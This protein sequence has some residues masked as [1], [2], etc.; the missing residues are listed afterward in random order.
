M[1]I[2]LALNN[3][4][5]FAKHTPCCCL[6]YKPIVHEIEIYPGK[7]ASCDK[8]ILRLSQL[9]RYASI[10]WVRSDDISVV[11]PKLNFRNCLDQ[12]SSNSSPPAL[13]CSK[14]SEKTT[15]D[16][17]IKEVFSKKCIHQKDFLQ[18]YLLSIGR[19]KHRKAPINLA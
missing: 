10:D 18:I 6:V 8:L 15:P 3:W 7:L 12:I 19:E 1:Q 16:I 13:C 4:D 17:S 2:L 9:S 11:G 14:D 5:V